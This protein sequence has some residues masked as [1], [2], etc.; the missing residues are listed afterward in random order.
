[1]ANILNSLLNFFKGDNGFGGYNLQA[2]YMI[3]QKGAVWINTSKPYEV[4]SSIPQFKAVIDKKALMFANMDLQLIDKKTGDIIEDSDFVKLIKNPNILQSMNDWLRQYKLQEQVYGN[5][6]MYKNKPSS[7]AK[8]P[9]ALWNVSPYY[10]KPHLT[11]K[12]WDQ[13]ELSGIIQKYEYTEHG[14]SRNFTPDEILYSRIND[15][16][17]PIIGCSPVMNLKFPL[18]NTKL[19]YEYRNVIMGEK[20]AIGILSN[21]SKDS[22]GSVPMTPEEKERIHDEYIK[23][24]GVKSGQKRVLLTEAALNWQPMT[25]PTKDLLLFEE[26]D[27]NMI[28]LCDA[29]GI[30][31]NIFSSKNA[32]YENV[33]NSM[34]QTYQDTI[35]PEAD[36]FTQS[37]SS[38]IGIPENI[39]LRA[40][41]DHI[42]ILKDAK[43]ASADRLKTMIESLN[44]AV[45]SG[46][47]ELQQAQLIIQNEITAYT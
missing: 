6:F 29:F 21:Q 32:T 24:N 2:S 14:K 13:I 44:N 45:A 38:F 27:A 25:Y 43:T 35:I 36:Q 46:L 5:Q 10:I 19:A 9:V 11:G 22:M 20:G 18:T 15:L 28:T 40:S 30:N 17:N 3:G 26:I 23:K 16:D 37:L 33:K 42:Q 12:L 34:I 8:Y 47:L 4:Y 7:L 39:E 31:I 1:M 41:Y